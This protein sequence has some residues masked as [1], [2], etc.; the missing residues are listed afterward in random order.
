MDADDW[1]LIQERGGS[2]PY[3]SRVLGYFG[4]GGGVVVFPYWS[5]V[6]LAVTLAAAPWIRQLNWRFSLRALLIAITLVAVVLGLV[7]WA[8]KS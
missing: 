4:Y 7:V 6:L 3:S 5:G 8:A 2:P 1:W